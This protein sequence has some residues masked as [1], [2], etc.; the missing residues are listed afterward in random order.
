MNDKEKLNLVCYDKWCYKILTYNERETQMEK[1]AIYNVLE[2]HVYNLNNMLNMV[3]HFYDITEDEYIKQ[4]HNIYTIIYMFEIFLLDY[5]N[6]NEEE[7]IEFFKSQN[8]V[9]ELITFLNSFI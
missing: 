3:R 9:I 2:E 1:V 8:E 7:L 4:R 5:D 6:L